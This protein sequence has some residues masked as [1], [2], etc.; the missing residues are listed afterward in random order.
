MNKQTKR[1]AIAIGIVIAIWVVVA[2]FWKAFFTFG[3][4]AAVPIELPEKK[5][6]SSGF[7]GGSEAVGGHTA[8]PAN[9]GV[10]DM[11]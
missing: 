6:T 11:Q 7:R 1:Y 5:K 10:W 8:G 9:T 3:D 2:N 4:K